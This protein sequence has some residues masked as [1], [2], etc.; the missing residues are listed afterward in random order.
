VRGTPPGTPVTYR[1]PDRFI[2]DGKNMTNF[3]RCRHL[4]EHV[5]LSTQR[6]R[7]L[8]ACE[9]GRHLGNHAATGAGQTRVRPETDRSACPGSGLP[10]TAAIARCISL[11][12]QMARTCRPAMHRPGGRPDSEH[13]AEYPGA[14]APILL[15]LLHDFPDPGRFHRFPCSSP[16][17]DTWGLKSLGTQALGFGG[18]LRVRP[19]HRAS[20]SRSPRGQ[21][22]RIDVAR[23]SSR[24]PRYSPAQP[25]RPGQ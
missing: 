13:L 9:P 2:L 8:H 1:P 3:H 14:F 12:K 19:R 25:T 23:M 7:M 6:R 18:C 24:S 5:P 16:P 21:C 11:R 10:L 4:G 20:A 22:G 15:P 17:S